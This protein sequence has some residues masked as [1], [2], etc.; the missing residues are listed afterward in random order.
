MVRL[1][2][3]YGHGGKDSGAIYN[4]RKESIDN[5]SIGREV[6]K[7]IRNLGIEVG[8]TR[9]TDIIMGLKERAN[10]ANNGYYDYFI[11]FHRNAFKPELANGAE[12]FVYSY[13]SPKADKLAHRIQI[14]L[15]NCGFKD[16][17]VKRANFYVL[18]YTKMP[19]ILIE[20]GFL[21][22]TIDNNIFDNKRIEI[23]HELTKAIVLETLR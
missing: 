11:S 10:F 2:F 13:A 3:D 7:R 14:A 5:L 22:N 15:I 16:R 23:I 17:G 8:E 18:K 6:A 4:G 1:C 19:A 9:T 12:T 21:D 20:I